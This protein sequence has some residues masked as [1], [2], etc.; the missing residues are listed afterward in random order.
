MCRM[1]IDADMCD[2]AVLNVIQQ[3]RQTTAHEIAKKT[4][5]TAATVQ[6]SIDRLKKTHREIDC[7]RGYGGGIF[8][9]PFAEKKEEEDMPSLTTVDSKSILQSDFDALQHAY[10][11]LNAK[12]NV[13]FEN[14]RSV[15]KR[16]RAE[17]D[18]FVEPLVYA[19][20]KKTADEYKEKYE[21]ATAT[22]EKA[23][24]EI[25]DLREGLN[26]YKND[27]HPSN[28][29]EGRYKNVVQINIGL[30]ASNKEL[31]NILNE[32]NE[33]L[34]NLAIGKANG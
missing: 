5:Y 1:T 20:T 17:Y 24:A 27:L 4:G 14:S 32:Q 7:I 33:R 15:E 26:K 3:K 6:K 19:N 30:E 9:E 28:D 25:K 10:D 8:W 21:T 13:L 23:M 16:V 29:Y 11:D 31:R 12:Y 22:L 2:K 34:L 18:G